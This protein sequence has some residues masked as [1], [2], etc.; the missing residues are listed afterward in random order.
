MGSL[1]IILLIS[2]YI[3]RKGCTKD[4]LQQTILSVAYFW[5]FASTHY[6]HATWRFVAALWTKSCEI[7]LSN[8]GGMRMTTLGFLISR[9]H[10]WCLS[11]KICFH[12]CQRFIIYI[13]CST[14]NAVWNNWNYN[15]RAGTILLQTH[16]GI[17]ITILSYWVGL[18]EAVFIHSTW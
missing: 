17:E 5:Q 15:S 3:Q 2:C 8:F 12:A 14:V 13:V 10:K 16:C 1:V 9:W 6:R 4:S 7:T 18:L 11:D